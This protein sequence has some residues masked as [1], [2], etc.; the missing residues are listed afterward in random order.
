MRGDPSVPKAIRRLRVTVGKWWCCGL[1]DQDTQYEANKD[2]EGDYPGDY[3]PD[4]ALHQCPSD[5]VEQ[6]SQDLT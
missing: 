4:Q 2:P 5:L 6:A 1:P 3:H